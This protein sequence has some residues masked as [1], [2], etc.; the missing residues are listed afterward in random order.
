MKT[1][2]NPGVA[3]LILALLWIISMAACAP[4]MAW[5]G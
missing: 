2:L 4:T 1:K 3:L 5:S